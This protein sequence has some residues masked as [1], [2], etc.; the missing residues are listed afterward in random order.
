MSRLSGGRPLDEAVV[1]DKVFRIH[2]YNAYDHAK[3]QNLAEAVKTSNING[4]VMDDSQVAG[5]A[6]EYAQSGGRSVNF[7]RFM[8]NE[9]KSANTS[10]AE[11]ITRNLKSPYAQGMQGLMGGGSSQVPMSAPSITDVSPNQ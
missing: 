10:E 11:K 1:N 2:S 7:N 6:R 3:L 8:V 9:I 5:F 4:Q